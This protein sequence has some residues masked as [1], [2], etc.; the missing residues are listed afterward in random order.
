MARARN[1][2]PAFFQ[3]DLLAEVDP[4]AR[5]LFAGLWT[6]ADRAGRLED[7]PKRIKA[8]VLPYDDC[9]IDML[10][11]QLAGRRFINRYLVDDDNF[12]EITNFTKHQNPHC[13]EPESTIPAPDKHGA[14]MVLLLDENRTGP[15]DSLLPITSTLNLLPSPAAK[16]QVVE[17]FADFWCA[18]PKKV[19]KPAAEKAWKKIKP[20]GQ[21]VADLM[22]GLERQAASEQWRKD[23][24][25]FIPNPATWLNGRRWEDEAPPVTVQPIQPASS[26]FAGAI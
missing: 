18:Y 6:V 14:N 22:A 16:G 4:L 20:T 26:I 24:G 8:A 25:Q 5:L 23:S 12:I 1:L 19:A 15:A 11:N 2:K 13:K 9:C 17:G 3:N 10:L 21:V 7:R